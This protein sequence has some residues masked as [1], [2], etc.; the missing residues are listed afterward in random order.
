MSGHSTYLDLLGGYGIVGFIPYVG[1]VIAWQKRMFDSLKTKIA[2]N[3]WIITSCIYHLFQIVNPIF[4]N[5]LIIFV[6][7][8]VVVVFL[9]KLDSFLIDEIKE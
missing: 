1:F 4:A 8:T 5:Y 6:Y 7:M 2:M 3:T 9:K